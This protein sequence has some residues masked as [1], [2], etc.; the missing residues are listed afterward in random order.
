MDNVT[1]I[2]EDA[3]DSDELELGVGQSFVRW[4]FS[5]LAG[6]AAQQLTSKGFD[7]AV[8]AIRA[9]RS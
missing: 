7:A 9:R 8:R 2:V 4:S 3:M 6:V 5:N 1:E